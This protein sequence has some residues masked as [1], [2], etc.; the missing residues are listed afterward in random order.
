MDNHIFIS[1]PYTTFS[2]FIN[3][4]VIVRLNMTL[5]GTDIHFSRDIDCPKQK[6]VKWVH[7]PTGSKW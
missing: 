5:K 7:E 2:Q 6:A 4:G 1:K 3:I